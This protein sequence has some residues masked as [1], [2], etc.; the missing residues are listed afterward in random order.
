[1]NN[2]W[3][4]LHRKIKKHWVWSDPLH[5]KIWIDFLMRANHEDKKILFDNNLI[6]VKRGS[7][8]TSLKKL[9]LDY[10][11]SIGKIRHLLGN[12][13]KDKMCER[14]TTQKATHITICNYS[15]YQN[16]QHTEST[17]NEN[18]M[19][20]ERKLNETNNNDTI[21]INNDNKG[22]IEKTPTEIT[23]ELWINV[24]LRNPGIVEL[25]FVRI[26]VE[27]F[28]EAK[29]KRILYELREK[30]FNSITTMKKA[31]NEDGSIKPKEDRTNGKPKRAISDAEIRQIAED[32]ENDPRIN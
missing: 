28:G 30:N 25:D 24:F 16:E 14:N 1:M 20:T 29:T 9:A 12:F 17:Q 13:E 32:I 31:I 19:K 22:G 26:L 11:C 3:I 10:N 4:S 23:R 27:R 7:F 15:D 18:R 5:L 21:M 2:G 8:I 6:E